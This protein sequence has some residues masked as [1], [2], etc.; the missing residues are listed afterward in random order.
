M[1]F[2]RIVAASFV[3][4]LVGCNK[5]PEVILA[6]PPGVVN[7]FTATPDAVTAPGQM[8][9]LAWTTTD[10]QRITLEQVGKGPV[11]I[12]STAGAGNVQVTIATDTTF[13]LSAAG[14]G[15]TDSKV[16]RVAVDSPMSGL[17]FNASPARIQADE[18]TTLFWSVPGATSVEIRPMG[19]APLDLGGQKGSGTVVVT[20]ASDTRYELTAGSQ[21]ATLDVVV[22][23]RITSFT[24]TA[25]PLAGEPVTVSWAVKGGG[26]RLTLTRAGVAAPLVTETSATNIAQGSFMEMAPMLAPDSLL[27]Y[28]LVVE[29]GNERVEQVLV[30]RIGGNLRATATVPGFVTAGTPFTLSWTTVAAAS[31]EVVRDGITIYVAPNAAGVAAGSVLLEPTDH[32]VQLRLIARDGKGGIVT[33]DRTV[34]AV[35][36]ASFVSFTSDLP[37]V[38]NGGDPVV[39]SWNVTNARDVRISDSSGAVVYSQTGV[40]DTG[41]VTVYPNRSSVTYTLNASNG[42]GSAVMPQTVVVTVANLGRLT[43]DQLAPL[44]G[45]ARVSGHTVVGG[46]SIYGLPSIEAN[47]AGEAFIDIVGAG[48]QSIS[49]VGPDSTA[50]VQAL[51]ETFSTIIFGRKVSANSLSISINGWF[52]FS[53]TAVSGT[54]N[55]VNLATTASEPLAIAPYWD[56][57]YDIG[58]SE[59]YWRLDTADGQRRLIVQWVDVEHDDFPG[60]QLT[61]QAQVYSSGKIVFAYQRMQGVPGTNVAAVGVTS[62]GEL[63]A[64]VAPMQPAAGTTFTMFAAPATLPQPLRVDTALPYTARVAIGTGFVEVEGS[65]RLAPGLFG[66]TEVNPRPAATLTNGEWIEVTNSSTAPID[67]NGMRLNFGGANTHVIAGSVPVAPNSAVVLAQAADLGDPTAGLTA[68]YVY[69]ATLAM[70]DT[71]GTVTLEVGGIAYSAASWNATSLTGAG[72]SVRTDRPQDGV[73][74]ASTTMASCSGAS[75]GTYG[76]QTGTPGTLHAA[77]APF[78]Y[79]LT[80][81]PMGNFEAIAMTGTQIHVG[82]DTVLTTVT[83][84]NPISYF[85]V[86][87]TT[88]RVDTNGFMTF[89]TYSFSQ[90]TNKSVPSSTAPAGTIA[91]FWDDLTATPGPGVGIYRLDRDPDATPMSG[92]EYTIVSWERFIRWN[93]TGHDLNFQVKAFANGDIEFHYGTMAGGMGT[94]LPYAQGSDATTWLEDPTGRMAMPIN[95]NSANNP[96]IAP[97]TAYRYTY[98]P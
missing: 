20:P 41:T 12:E 18:P 7:T 3:V 88:L 40:L 93:Q 17:V 2:T 70:S 66:I 81:L 75:T 29:Q 56:D 87:G 92:D 48:G 60:S 36:V 43:F 14:E 74:Y 97:N 26:T 55:N 78:P 6:P 69:P 4:A 33:V 91:P 22:I 34:T 57:L 65:G 44:T 5:A 59:I 61:F 11:T 76:V 49:Y 82:G 54:D 28:R 85:G 68:A 35:G 1:N 21:T 37:G 9:T 51:G 64:V 94:S 19:G 96:G 23:P 46:T 31:L 32:V 42:A 38:T 71:S 45:L 24:S 50:K 10:A 63:D 27:T 72:I 53:T 62:P 25:S 15:G 13:V 39:L 89:A 47:R 52:I 80:Q 73:I 86:P 98:T 84:P 77:C 90:T 79:R 58:P 16:L 67:L 83:L 8:V 95:I 30:V